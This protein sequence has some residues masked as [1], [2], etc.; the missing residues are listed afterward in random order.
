YRRGCEIEVGADIFGTTGVCRLS[1][2]IIASQHP[3]IFGRDLAGP[4][5][6]SGL[7]IE[8]DDSVTGLLLRIAV[9]VPGCDVDNVALCIGR[10]CPPDSRTGRSPQLSSRCALAARFGSFRDGVGLPDDLSAIRVESA[11]A[12]SKRAAL[13]IRTS[14]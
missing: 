13:I 3:Y 6:F 1:G 5:H 2:T 9:A 10:W 4:F 11:Y 8:G 7:Q 14:G 12:S